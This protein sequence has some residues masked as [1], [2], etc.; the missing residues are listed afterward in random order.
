MQQRQHRAKATV[1]PQYEN[2]HAC[3]SSHDNH[4]LNGEHDGKD[5]NHNNNKF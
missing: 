1:D 5:C 4:N 3:D 2:N